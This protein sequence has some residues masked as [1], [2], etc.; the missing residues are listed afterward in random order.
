MA[1]TFYF[2]PLSSYCHKVLLALYENGTPFDGRT[3][4]LGDADERARYR[5]LSP[6]L[7]IPVLRDEAAGRTV[8]ET[9]IIIEYLD[10]H[11][12]GPRALFPRE[13]AQALEARL[14]DRVFDAYVM[15]PMG[16]IVGDRLRG[17]G[18]HD[19]RGV[20]EAKATLGQAYD[21]IERQLAGRTWAIG[22]AFTVADCAAAPALF[23]A[24][25]L[26]PF[27][28]THPNIAAYFERLVARPSFGRVLAEAQPWF[29]YYPY[30]EA[31]PARFLGEERVE[32]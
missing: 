22:E 32:A 2:H 11:H 3:V 16:K 8:I 30:R 23:Y 7:K 9:S 4:D 1:L 5:E 18:E 13:E 19:P 27:E 17:E 15:T 14:W 28:T 6:M 12:P 26:V 31:L 10:R 24:A 25:T 20:A 21:M 29:R